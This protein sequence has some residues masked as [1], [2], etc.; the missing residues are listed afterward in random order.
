MIAPSTQVLAL[1]EGGAA[2][3]AIK[4]YVPDRI[5]DLEKYALN[6]ANNWEDIIR[7]RGERDALKSMLRLEDA[8]KEHR[9][10]LALANTAT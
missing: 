8:L 5:R 1:L 9:Q 6:S 2:I 7:V 4:A 3:E 10:K